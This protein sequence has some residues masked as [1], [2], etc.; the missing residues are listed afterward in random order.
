MKAT[1]VT[2][3]L[4]VTLFSVTIE[5]KK[6]QLAIFSERHAEGSLAELNEEMQGLR[7]LLDERYSLVAQLQKEGA[8]D[9]NYHEVLSDVNEIKGRMLALQEKWRGTALAQTQRDDE[10]YAFWDQEETTL[11]QMIMEYGA[12]D[13][14]YVIPAEMQSLKLNLHSSLPIPRESW[15]ELL[16]L[17]LAQNGVGVRK[18]N[19]YAKQL[20][21]LKHDLLAVSAIT[22]SKKDLAK[23]PDGARIIHIFTPP[24]ER[25]RSVAYFFERFRDIKKTHVNQIGYKV[26]I[27]AQK[28]EVEKLISLYDAVW[29]KES[30]KTSKVV[31]LTKMQAGEMEKILKTYFGEMGDRN[32]MMAMRGGED[33]S[34]TV[35]AQENAIVL[36]GM[37]EVVK[38]AEK[39]I[40]ETEEQVSDPCEMTV[41]WYTCR[42]SDPLEMAEVLQKVYESLICANVESEGGDKGEMKNDSDVSISVT[43]PYYNNPGTPPSVVNP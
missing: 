34:V 30:E 33:L 3:L 18:L 31:P 25:A 41:Y 10:G 38:K 32:R 5:E 22:S 29:E 43:P 12:T 28:E 26:A 20:Y 7:S 37:K 23:V 21:Y 4:A 15:S 8:C 40:V 13:F 16:E 24:P 1:I 9:E 6:E 42:H 27:V 14:L 35:L 39:I 2:S 11:S 36:V 17:M 19:A